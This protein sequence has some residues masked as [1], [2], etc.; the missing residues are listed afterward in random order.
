MVVFFLVLVAASAAAA[1]LEL[2]SAE[3]AWLAAHPV[4]RTGFA[5]G[6]APYAFF[7]DRKVPQG[8]AT[9]L[10][11]LVAARL[12][13]R[14]EYVHGLNWEQLLEATRRLEV[15]LLTTATFRPDRVSYLNFTHNYLSTPVVVMTREQTPRLSRLDQL[16]GQRVALVKRYSSSEQA[17]ERFPKM[18]AVWAAEPVDGLR[19]VSEGRAHAYIGVLGVNTTTASRNG[20]SN[21][22]V[23]TGFADNGQAYGVREDWPE[24]IPLL[25]KALDAIPES[26]KNAIY[27]RWLPV[28]FDS[29]ANTG[30]VL[31]DAV[32][33]RFAALPP[34]RV[35][36]QRNRPPF[37][38]VDADGRH[39][40]LAA[41]V[42]RTLA[43]RT[44]LSFTIVAGASSE[45][46]LESLSAGELDLVLSAN[47]AAPRVPDR[48]LSRPYLTSSL[49]VFVRKG[50]TFLG[51]ISDLH[52]HRVAVPDGGY[53]QE[54]LRAHPR[55][56]LVPQENLQASAQAL[57]DNKV[58]YLVAET[59]SALRAIEESS[60]IGLRYAG[61]LSE[62]PVR[63]SMVVGTG[64]EELHELMD[65]GLASITG[66]QAA[67]I[68]RRWVGAPLA[69]G[70]TRYQVLRWSL[71]TAVLVA[72][73]AL[74]FV[75]WNRRLKREVARQT[76]F[77]AAL[78]RSNEAM[79][80]CSSSEELFPQIC[81]IAVEFGGM[82]MAWIS[83]VESD[84]TVVRPVASFGSQADA[85][86]REIEVLVDTNRTG[87]RDAAADV[88]RRN[89]PFWCQ[90]IQH[91]QRTAPWLATGARFGWS[92]FACLP[93]QRDDMVVGTLSLYGERRGV[94]DED[95]RHLLMDMVADIGFALTRFA[96]AAERTQAEDLARATAEQLRFVA[97]HTPVAIAHCDCAQHYRFVNQRYADMFGLSP[98]D[99]VGRSVA[100]MLGE[101][102]YGHARPYIEAALAGRS[103]EY[104]LDLPVT[105]DGPRVVHPIYA[106]EF[107]ANGQVIGLVAAIHDITERRRTA[108]H[109]LDVFER[110]TDAFVALD[111][112]W[113]YTYVNAKAA[114]MFGRSAADLVGKNIWVEFP[115]GVGQ[116]FHRTYE[117]VMTEQQPAFLEEYYPPYDLW[118]ENRIYPSADG[119]TIYFHD[120]T[121]RK[122]TEAALEQRAGELATINALSKEVNASL[123]LDQVA[124]AV[125]SQSIANVGPN[126][127]MLF[128]CEGEGL[129]LLASATQGTAIGNDAI[130]AQGVGESLCGL[131]A[132]Q[133]V[134]LFSR[135]IHGDPRCSRSDHKDAGVRTFAAL[136][137][138]RGNSVIGV[139]GMASA[140]EQDFE[141]RAIFL[142][143]LA[144]QAA[145]G[146]QNAVMHREIQ[147][148]ARELE[149]RVAARTAELEISKDLAES[150]DRAKSAFLAN[151]SHEIRTPMNAILG[152]A[153]LMKRTE[154]S[155]DQ[156]GRL[157]K[158]E[159][160]GQHL[161]SIINDILDLSKIEAGRVQLESTDF[162]LSAIFDN[163]RSL[164][165]EQARTKGLRIE[166][167]PDSVPVWLRGDPTRLRQAL[168]N[169]ASNAVKFTEHGSIALRAD[170]LE[171]N[172]DELRV[173]FAVQDTGIGIAAEI[174]PK[175]FN[176]FMQADVST[177][178]KHGG[179]GLGLAITQRL[180]ELMGGET[181]VDSTPGVGSTFWFTACLRHGHG[182]VPALPSMSETDAATR[183]RLRH[184]GARLLLV[185]D[186][187]I[188]REVALELLHGVGLA[189]ETAEDGRQAVDKA[190][191]G[192]YDLILMDVQMPIMDGLEA[193]VA[194]RALPGW[195]S[196][197]ML[198]MTANA[199]DE[200]RRACVTA[201]LDDFV[202]KPVD[203]NALFATLLKWL[204]PDPA[205]AS[206]AMHATMAA[207]T[208]SP[209]STL[210]GA[211][212]DA[213]A[214]RRRL[215]LV[216]G[217]DAGPRLEM[218]HGKVTTYVRLLR[219]FADSHG[220]DATRL[221]D[222]L[223]AGHLPQVQQLT[224]ALM[225]SAGNLGAT[226]VSATAKTL[227]AAI[228]QGALHGEIERLT[229]DLAGKLTS[230]IG[231]I[232]SLLIEE[233]AAPVDLDPATVTA[234]LARLE[235]LLQNSDTAAN[236][237][238]RREAGVLKA[239]L[240]NAADDILRRIGLFDYIGALAALHGRV[241]E[242]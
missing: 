215:A 67:A 192:A 144:E 7:D 119:L 218:L 37:D 124:H 9:E 143:T 65:V 25:E 31:D 221:T 30:A 160:A 240:G 126:L 219:L 103:A 48:R 68:H 105:P 59:T 10:T 81:R 188:N 57:L 146:I 45:Q 80:R 149:Q 72:L 64:T 202:A 174:L 110:I 92:V 182:I 210:D 13:V 241:R 104:D 201:G 227:H 6:M 101:P 239:A 133:G 161:L 87:G 16:N 173:R 195:K 138:R 141:A 142:E 115:E 213:T 112:N 150:A 196:K 184:G 46:L 118:F 95:A 107:D 86:L 152:L 233:G 33:A 39:D 162:H 224:H 122:R 236:G 158:I 147:H 70:I 12:G 79:A 139:L 223:A 51:E 117:K 3:R 172:G 75:L 177:T 168:L 136:P 73:G 41:D 157:A 58:D 166:I 56:T 69:I 94:F 206:V 35:G 154:A 109:Q 93:I 52:G 165:G 47:G 159:S 212:T 91:A 111:K 232:R 90:D 234:I 4:I 84:S 20:I 140:D 134:A 18:K 137:L 50:D 187:A 78:T 190:A 237:L 38:F 100:Q 189:V 208:V 29:A 230:L 66:E 97:D 193:T 1:T 113:N 229:D 194:I 14:L 145:A 132:A 183:L 238:A 135:D 167:D 179:T 22:K 120:I 55:I 163:V 211:M 180:V 155:P 178:R 61:A 164:I 76:R 131:A 204:S 228:R 242:P 62:A 23:N 26:E 207:D 226:R 96:L 176:T 43:Q 116:V 181:G 186:N 108:Q 203:P 11:E 71:V 235:S 21:L 82:Q 129:R 44:G 17:M 197:P 222:A 40:G 148:H 5:S 99:F 34:L 8:V 170:L 156:A 214:W 102:A 19:A 63:L 171:D 199:F 77:Y 53:A 2:S 220:E 123:D 205:G 175:L 191:A 231:D 217:L 216:S 121:E 225:G 209:A 54:M 130:A 88:I 49:G 28:G 127:A 169:F 114:Q 125:V 198:A 106:P 200:D 24:L 151:M 74:A 89:Q 83:L 98:A 128:L 185:E 42:L 15:D 85:Y 27:A 36:V 32:L 153:Y 60:F